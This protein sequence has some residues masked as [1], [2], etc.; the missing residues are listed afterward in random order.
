M[1][2]HSS[3]QILR[4]LILTKFSH[5]LQSSRLT[6]NMQ[7]SAAQPQRPESVVTQQPKGAQNLTAEQQRQVEGMQK[8]A[9]I[10]KQRRIEAGLPI[11]GMVQKRRIAAFANFAQVKKLKRGEGTRKLRVGVLVYLECFR[12]VGEGRL[13]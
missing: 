8:W 1:P 11:E 6:T 9:E 5:I 2:C 4:N 10:R 7:S 12:V 13:H 3:I